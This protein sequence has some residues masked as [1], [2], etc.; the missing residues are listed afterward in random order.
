MAQ[1][2][3]GQFKIKRFF[4]ENNRFMK[5]QKT[6]KLTWIT[7]YLISSKFTKVDNYDDDYFNDELNDILSKIDLQ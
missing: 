4:V 2:K 5:G 3:L 6:L 7:F 1:L